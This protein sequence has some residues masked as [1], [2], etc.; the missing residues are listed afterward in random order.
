MS[1]TDSCELCGSEAVCVE[2]ATLSDIAL[3]GVDLSPAEDEAVEF[4]SC[5]ALVAVCA[6]ELVV[7]AA[8]S[9]EGEETAFVE[10]TAVGA[11]L[12]SDVCVEADACFG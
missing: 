3:S 12:A 6:V 11:L 7:P 2:V 4:E 10:V 9:L 1:L 5:V 8:T